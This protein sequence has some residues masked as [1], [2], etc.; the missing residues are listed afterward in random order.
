MTKEESLKN[1]VVHM[2]G[3]A[4]IDPIWLWRWQEGYQAICAT[5]RNMLKLMDEFPAFIFTCSSAA[6]YE[7]VEKGDPDLFNEIRMR[8]REGRWVPIG[9]WWVEPDCNIP[10]GE[11]FI[12]QALYGQRYFK[13][14][15]GFTVTTGYNIDSFG[16]NG[17]LPQ[18]LRKCGLVNYVFMRPNPEENKKIPGFIFWWEGVDGSRVLC[19]RVPF[20]YA[21]R[22]SLEDHIMRVL[23]VV[24]APVK[25]VMCFYGRGDHGGG[26]TR[27]DVE[28][29]LNLQK[30]EKFP[31]IIFSSPEKFFKT[32]RRQ[33][34]LLPVFRGDLQHHARGCYSLHSEV[35]RNNLRAEKVLCAAEKF[36]AIA[37]ILFG[38][39]YPQKSLTRAWKNLLFTQFHDILAGTSIKEAYE[40]VR[41]IQGEA[42]HRGNEELNYA[43]QAIASNI[44]TEGEGIPLIVFNP[45]AWHIHSP[46]EV[47]G[48]NA[49]GAIVDEDGK[50]ILVQKIQSSSITS[51]QRIVFIAD[52][53]PLGYRVYWKVNDGRKASTIRSL[54]SSETYLENDW[55]RLEIDPKT[56]YI[57]RL[58]D[59]RNEVE[60]FCGPACV[61]TVIRDLSDTWSH[62]VVR[63]EDEIGTFDDADVKLIENGPVRASIRAES[64]YG[65]SLI[66]IFFTLYRDLPYVECRVSVNWQEQRKM[67]KLR[68]P[69]NITQPV[70]TY[71][72]PYGYIE[73]PC[74]GEEQPGQRWIDITGTAINMNGETLTYGL[75]L[76]ND[77]K[78]SYDVNGSKMSLTVLRS[79]PYAHHIPYELD[80]NATY[81]YIDQGW[82]DFI[83][84]LFPHR[85]SWR[86]TPVVKIAEE[87]SFKPMVI[88]SHPHGGVLQP[89]GS[90]I[91]VSKENV[92]VSVLKKHEDSDDLIL[93]CYETFGKET[94]AEIKIPFLN[95]SW[96]A[97]FKPCEIKTFI[98]PRRPELEVAE[99]DMLEFLESPQRML[100]RLEAD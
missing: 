55:L 61:P 70:A 30:R 47:E 66:R 99:I 76:C 23:K 53:P 49:D 73:R 91:K 29:I 78:Y 50:I 15:F 25:D 92:L 100:K 68:F 1:F 74:N 97:S 37:S 9:G 26:P 40:D 51:R 75:S 44:N 81:H 56:G 64:R 62:G 46:V 88:V 35:K 2:I 16:H 45:H 32:I 52:V 17:M 6:F 67:L 80:P 93:R 36:S 7:W 21:T 12:R 79:P 63:F 41:D 86:K 58:Y 4:H 71:S 27:K 89:H 8:V 60:V 65:S 38:R 84:I 11:S 96:K 19:Y 28:T 57:R 48:I 95:R 82:Q 18:I 39:R 85:D 69:V 43:I 22:N 54:S 24:K 3:N 83:F 77:G 33:E 94:V 20:S 5:F 42:I 14:K 90:F 98:I 31:K 87:I 10:D 59:K 72:I 13:E 34:K